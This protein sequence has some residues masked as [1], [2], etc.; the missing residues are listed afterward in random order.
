MRKAIYAGSFDPVHNGHLWVIREG[1][2][3]FDEL[4]VAVGYNP[5]KKGRFSLDDRLNLLKETI[6]DLENVSVDSFHGEFLFNYAER[7]GAGY[8]LKG[9]RNGKDFEYEEKLLRYSREIQPKIQKVLLIPPAKLSHI[10]SSDVMNLIGFE[11]WE[12]EVKKYVPNEVY[13]K[14][15][16]VYR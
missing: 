8:V 2:K 5:E 11:G 3:L 15:Q 14:I 1:A 9:V 12:K 13:R 7:R 4:V 16:E 6:R 10:S